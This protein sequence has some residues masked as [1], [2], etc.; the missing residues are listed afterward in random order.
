VTD[1]ELDM[2]GVRFP[3]EAR[4]FSLLHSVQTGYEADPTVYPM[5]TEGSFP[6]RSRGRGAKLTTNL[7]LVPRSRMMEL[8]LHSPTSLWRGA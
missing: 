1:Y 8:Y 7:H 2:T 5:G 4:D 6:G 3:A